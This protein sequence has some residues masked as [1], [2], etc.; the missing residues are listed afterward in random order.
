M[1]YLIMAYSYGL[2]GHRSSYGLSSYGSYSYG[3]SLSPQ[4]SARPQFGQP[5]RYWGQED[6]LVS[7]SGE[8]EK[9][10]EAEKQEDTGRAKVREGAI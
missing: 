2:Y 4:D 5:M 1:A 3:P 6:M 8:E 7:V 9:G 10:K